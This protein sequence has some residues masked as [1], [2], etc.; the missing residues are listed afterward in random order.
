MGNKDWTCGFP[1]SLPVPIYSDNLS[2]SSPPSHETAANMGGEK[3]Q[4]SP[5][6]ELKKQSLLKEVSC[7]GNPNP[8]SKWVK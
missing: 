5:E 1:F 2:L 8:N 4:D 3:E 7:S 6:H